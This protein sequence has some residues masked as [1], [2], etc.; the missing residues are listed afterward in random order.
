MRRLQSSRLEATSPHSADLARELTDRLQANLAE[1]RA[2]HRKFEPAQVWLEARIAFDRGTQGSDLEA[3][4]LE[5]DR[6][7]EEAERR[8][9]QARAD[10]AALADRPSDA[11]TYR[12]ILARATGPLASSG[13]QRRTCT[14]HEVLHPEC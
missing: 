11:S 2:R 6:K 14:D 10:I 9:A 1:W 13:E 3:R 5:L 7:V 12:E 8:I 4:K